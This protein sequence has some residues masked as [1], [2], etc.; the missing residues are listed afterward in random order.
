MTT[1]ETAQILVVLEVAYPKFY[2]NTSDANKKAAF[3]LWHMAF[4]N[5]DYK[6]VNYALG[7][8][9]KTCK[10]PPTI[11]DLNEK[12]DEVRNID[13]K[14]PAEFWVE[15]QRAVSN[16]QYKVAESFESLSEPVKKFVGSPNGLRELCLS[17]LDIF[18]TVT[19]GQ[20]L[21]QIP[22]IINKQE[23]KLKIPQN[24]R[25]LISQ[26]DKTMLLEG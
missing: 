24:I 11:A 10:F 18:N 2:I 14:T 4:E 26:L 15:L 13:K 21:K 16:G 1:Q 3:K 7:E 22:I 19:R 5:V 17:E 25:D 6:L 8:V 20:F 9:I 12:I 23:N